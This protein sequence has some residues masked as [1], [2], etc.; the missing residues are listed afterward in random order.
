MHTN[1]YNKNRPQA[2]LNARRSEGR[3]AE[4]GGY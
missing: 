3:Y 1:I 2:L 4:R